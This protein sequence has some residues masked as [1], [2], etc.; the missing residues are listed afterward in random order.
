MSEGGG[1]KGEE[2][3]IT[4]EMHYYCNPIHSGQKTSKAWERVINP[5]RALFWSRIS[6]QVDSW[7]WGGTGCFSCQKQPNCPHCP[8]IVFK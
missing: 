3:V 1:C 7:D 5:T 4:K 2:D 8:P 6:E